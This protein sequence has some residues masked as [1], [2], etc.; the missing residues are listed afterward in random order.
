M[1]ASHNVS[2]VG[3]QER[4]KGSGCANAFSNATCLLGNAGEIPPTFSGP[5][6]SDDGPFAFLYRVGF[7]R[8]SKFFGLDSVKRSKSF[9]QNFS[10][11]D[12]APATLPAGR[13]P[14]LAFESNP[15]S[16]E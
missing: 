9:R 13:V 5:S 6:S 4:R 12:H 10:P 7:A 15:D 2:D 16:Y 3:L 8:E 11:P 1:L 14:A